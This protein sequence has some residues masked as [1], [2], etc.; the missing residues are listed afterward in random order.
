MSTPCPS[1]SISK[2]RISK[3]LLDPCASV[4]VTSEVCNPPLAF[5]R[6]RSNVSPVAEETIVRYYLDPGMILGWY[7]PVQ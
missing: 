7:I 6:I 5:T 4:N 2:Y 3:N 1:D